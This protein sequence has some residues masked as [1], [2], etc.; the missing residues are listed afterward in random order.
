MPVQA[1]FSSCRSQRSSTEVTTQRIQG[2]V[3]DFDA[4]VGLGHITSKED[5]SRLFHCIE[6]ADGTRAIDVGARV[7]FVPVTRFG[8]DE[9]T[10]IR[11]E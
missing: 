9:A 10:D 8:H 2:I 1:T 5:H 4:A 11:P 3:T 6:I 7:T